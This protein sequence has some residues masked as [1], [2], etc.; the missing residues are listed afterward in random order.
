MSNYEN[1][2]PEVIRLNEKAVSYLNERNWGE[3]INC[4]EQALKIDPNFALSY[5][6]LGTIRQLQG[7][8]L[9]AESCYHSALKIAPNMAEVYANLGSLYA[10]NKRWNEAINA[11]EKALEIRPNMAGFYR[12]LAKVFT[13]CGQPERAT[14]YWCKAILLSADPVSFQD[15]LNFG[16]QL[17]QQQQLEK[18][19]AIYQKAIVN[20]PNQSDVFYHH[21]GGIFKQQER[22]EEAV[23]CYQKAI[24]INPN[25]FYYYYGLAQV[26]KTQE[27]WSELIPVCGQAIALKPDVDWLYMSLGD[28][29]LETGE[30][31]EA[32]ANYRQAI[33][34]NPQL[35]WLHQKLG[36]ALKLAGHIDEAIAAYQKA[37]ELKPELIWLYEILA[38]LLTEKQRWQELQDLCIEGLKRK[39]DLLKAYHHFAQI[40]AHRGLIED[41]NNA[42]NFKKLSSKFI[43]E[44]LP[45][46]SEK[47]TTSPTHPSVQYILIYPAKTIEIKPANILITNLPETFTTCQIST[48]DFGVAIVENGRVWGDMAT[49]AVFTDDGKLVTDLASGG[50]EFVAV[51]EH[52]PPPEEIDGVVAFLSVRFGAGYFH[53]MLDIIA[54]F[55]LLEA[56]GIDLNSIDKF[57][58]NAWETPYQKQALETLKIPP[59]KIISNKDINHLKAAQIIIPTPNLSSHRGLQISQWNCDFLKHTFCPS[60]GDTKQ[61]IYI[62]RTLAQS[63]QVL[64]NSQVIECLTQFNIKPV[65]LES[66][67]LEQQAELF[68]TSE[69]IISPHG[70]GLTNLAFCQTGTTVIEI[71]SPDYCPSIYRLLSGICELEYYPILGDNLPENEPKLIGKNINIVINIDRLM[72]T[73]QAA[74]LA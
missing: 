49:S 30:I 37:I 59:K 28:S 3:S 18:A 61:R 67:T 68:A 13:Q 7:D 74:G 2:Q 60:L 41:A 63:R 4:C 29:L 42:L 33:T 48:G 39:P 10:Q 24:E 25:Q 55:H 45:N 57:V 22:W 1:V 34:L 64:N 52:L 9:A 50:A 16:N 69:V 8:F 71:L 70:A 14:E 12:N 47:T 62:D 26:L 56:A 53:W 51:S 38:Q 58:V 27:K 21:L 19:I 40:L 5:K 65:Q 73:I 35:S 66:M 72:Q 17:Q 54:R 46:L 15:Y 43:R 44:I 11:Y 6:T 23:K 31:E 32:I 36:H 20:Y